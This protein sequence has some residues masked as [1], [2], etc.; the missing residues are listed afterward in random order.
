VA[1]WAWK[2]PCKWCK[3]RHS[4]MVV[5][6]QV[7]NL[8]TPPA[9]RIQDQRDKCEEECER[10]NYSACGMCTVNEITLIAAHV[11]CQMFLIF[12]FSGTRSCDDIRAWP[13]PHPIPGS[14]GTQ[15]WANT[16]SYTVHSEERNR[17]KESV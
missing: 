6:Y 5:Y 9:L 15:V 16:L 8:K 14:G 7:L 3:D 10:N 17:K 1:C 4:L 13:A 11:I 12:N 2:T